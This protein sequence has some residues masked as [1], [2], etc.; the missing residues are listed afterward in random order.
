MKKLNK[1]CLAKKLIKDGKKSH[2]INNGKRRIY[3]SACKTQELVKDK[4]KL[5]D[6]GGHPHLGHGYSFE[7]YIKAICD[8]EYSWVNRSRIDIRTE[9][10]PYDTETFDIVV[11]HEA[12]EHFWLMKWGGMLSWDGIINFWNESYRVLKKGGVFYLSTRNRVCPLAINHIFK[13][14]PVQVAPSKLNR[15]GH[16]REF[17]P[18]DLRDIVAHTNLF[19]SYTIYSQSSIPTS[20]QKDMN[21]KTLAMEDF[22][23][24]KFLQEETY[25]TLH[26]ISR[27]P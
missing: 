14:E 24:K 18:S 17:S 13:N 7:E 5:L 4:D 23:G 2:Y 12:I 15:S 6:I 22:L 27:K 11:C 10:L 1:F 8:V 9:T 3:N 16:V 19:S 26:F 20:L 25:D 21:K